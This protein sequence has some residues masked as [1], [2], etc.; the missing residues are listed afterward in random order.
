[1][2]LEIKSTKKFKYLPCGH[3][4]WFD[5]EPDGS[6]G[7][8]ASVHGYDREVE[9]TFAGEV[10]EMGWIVPFGELGKVKKF[11]EYYFDHTTVLP[12]NDPRLGQLT[13]E[14]MAPGGILGTVRVLPSGVSMEMSSLFIWEH[15]NYYIHQV[16]Q[17][18]CYVAK[19][20]VFEHDRNSGIIEVDKKTAMM[21]AENKT[22]D[23]DVML[24]MIPRWDLEEPKEVVRR[25]L[26]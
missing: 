7:E 15:V 21:N 17:G 25:N 23:C 11:L 20:Q 3:A 10:D 24:P 6:P 8:C 5:K 26:R 1:M 19:V 22:A 2:S 9:F 14:L 12:A 16:T 13:D 4:Q 18:R